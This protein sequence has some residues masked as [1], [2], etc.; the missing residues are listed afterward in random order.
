MSQNLPIYLRSELNEIEAMV[1]KCTGMLSMF[2]LL[3]AYFHQPESDKDK[4]SIELAE[5]TFQ[6]NG[7]ISLRNKDEIQMCPARLTHVFVNDASLDR[8]G[9]KERMQLL[10]IDVQEI[11]IMNCQWIHECH[12]LNK[13]I[14]DKSYKIVLD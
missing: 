10:N 12:L 7:G 4:A 13:K 2:R 5:L 3:T 14:C 8:N 6:I 1:S 9:F 11:T